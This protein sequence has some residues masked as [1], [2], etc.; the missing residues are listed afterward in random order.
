MMMVGKLPFR[1]GLRQL[2]VQ[3]VE[4]VATGLDGLVGVE[5]EEVGVA[6]TVAVAVLRR[7]QREVLVVEGVVLLMVADARKDR[8]AREQPSRRTEQ[9]ANPLLLVGT[10]ID[11]V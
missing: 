1:V 2:A 4:L 6:V 5:D 3:P 9:V 7:G 8:D 11:D 10:V